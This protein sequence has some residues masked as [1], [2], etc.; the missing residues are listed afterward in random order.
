[1]TAWL[2]EIPSF[3]RGGFFPALLAR[4]PTTLPTPLS[5]SCRSCCS[6]APAN[7]RLQMKADYFRYLAE[8][9]DGAA[10][11]EI[12]DKSSATYSEASEKAASG[13]APTH[14]IRLG[15]AL[16][17]SVFLYEVTAVTAVTDERR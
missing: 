12:A 4:P 15:L 6:R 2:A 5:R 7:A 11:T 1:M 10:K 3:L 13:L 16:N 17:F 9:K 8:F 14:P